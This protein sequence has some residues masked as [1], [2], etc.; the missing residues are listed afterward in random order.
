L[1][2]AQILNRKS[3]LSLFGDFVYQTGWLA[4]PMQRVYFSDVANYFIGDPTQINNYQSST[5][6]GL[7]QLGDDIER[8]PGSRLKIPFGMKYNL[9]INE[10]FVLKSYYRF[11]YDDWGIL[12]HTMNIEV[13]VKIANNWTV[14]PSYRFYQQTA[15]TYFAPFDQHLSTEEYYTSDYDL[16]AYIAN[17][18]GAGL[19]YTDVFL[20]YHLWKIGLKNVYLNYAYYARNSGL[21]AHIITFGMKMVVDPY[22][23]NKTKIKQ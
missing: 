6:L 23:V 16:S 19:K 22:L 15:S 5:N 8:L 11:Y 12:S 20:K 9:F 18:F 7:F 1:N 4:N 3:Q 14:Y 13:P 17:Q 21:A 2:F 10:H